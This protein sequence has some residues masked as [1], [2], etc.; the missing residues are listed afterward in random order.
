MK[1]RNEIRAELKELQK[2]QMEMEGELRKW[3][4]K[5][6]HYEAQTEQLQGMIR[7]MQVGSSNW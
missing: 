4:Q 7:H 2:K 5:E 1:S 3:R 6:E